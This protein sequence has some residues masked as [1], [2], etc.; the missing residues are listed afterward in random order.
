MIS[1]LAGALLHE[2]LRFNL[3]GQFMWL[4]FIAFMGFTLR[5]LL[6]GPAD[7]WVQAASSTLLSMGVLGTFAGIV[8]GLSGFN[9]GNI[10]DRIGDVLAGLSTAFYSSLLAMALSLVFKLVQIATHQKLRESESADASD[11]IAEKLLIETANGVKQLRQLNVNTREHSEYLIHITNAVA[12]ASDSSGMLGQMAVQRKLV[13]EGMA[14]LVAEMSRL[15]EQG[16]ATVE[17]LA[18]LQQQQQKFMDQ[19]QF[20]ER[21]LKSH[22]DGLQQVLMTLPNRR[23]FRALGA[24]ITDLH[25]PAVVPAAYPG[26]RS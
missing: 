5:L 4:I 3:G 20:S 18:L 22:I 11:D 16:S 8:V 13:G 9:A 21:D 23:D 7:A 10:D 24:I 12:D 17:A 19:R 26:V 1:D 6:R 2:M 15:R 25:G 14:A